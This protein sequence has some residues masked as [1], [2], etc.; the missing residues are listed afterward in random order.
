MASP[1]AFVK[2]RCLW[3]RCSGARWCSPSGSGWR[4]EQESNIKPVT[5]KWSCLKLC[6][7]ATYLCST[8]V[9]FSTSTLFQ[10]NIFESQFFL[11]SYLGPQNKVIKTIVDCNDIIS[12]T[13]E[14]SGARKWKQPLPYAAVS[15]NSI[16]QVC[17][18]AI[19]SLMLSAFQRYTKKFCRTY[20]V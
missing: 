14:W 12:A 3:P 17:H 13:S 15:F 18:S 4:R 6:R 19:G 7:A 16:I 2:W 5:A 1:E 10:I 9:S 20:T 8:E 11:C